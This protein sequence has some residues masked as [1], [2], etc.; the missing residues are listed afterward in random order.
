MQIKHRNI[1]VTFKKLRG[2]TVYESMIQLF[3]SQKHCELLRM[4]P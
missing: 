1:W 3:K 4:R 2:I